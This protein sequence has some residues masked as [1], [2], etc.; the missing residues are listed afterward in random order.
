MN[1]ATD[2]ER[3]PTASGAAASGSAPVI[4]L[5]PVLGR[6]TSVLEPP[7]LAGWF[8]RVAPLEVD[9]GSGDGGFLLRYAPRHPERNFLAVERLLGRIRK[10]DRK[11]PRLGIANLRALRVDAV[12]LVRYLLPANSVAAV[13]VYFPDP[14]PKKKHRGRRLIQPG[15][16]ADLRR[17][18]APGGA[19]HLRTDDADYF[20][21]MREVFGAA[22][23]FEATTSPAELL[24]VPTDFEEE[25]RAQGRSTLHAAYR[26]KTEPVRP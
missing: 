1:A 10:L 23:G 11:A 21:Q 26:K 12:Y 20:A 25:F 13:H 16:A 18:L 19:V 15:F 22:E 8:G 6:L 14:W 5:G 3:G 9:L 7:D 17:V 4:P 24:A 2:H